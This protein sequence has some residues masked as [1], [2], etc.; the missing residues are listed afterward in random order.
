MSSPGDDFSGRHLPSTLD[1]QN[2][3]AATPTL[4][5]IALFS[6]PPVSPRLLL[7]FFFLPF[8]ELLFGVGHDHAAQTGTR[9]ELVSQQF[10]VLREHLSAFLQ[11]QERKFLR[12]ASTAGATA[13]A[14]AEPQLTSTFSGLAGL[15][16][17][18][19]LIRGLSWYTSARLILPHTAGEH[20]RW[21]HTGWERCFYL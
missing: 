17:S 5:V 21:P 11:A 6:F 8:A 10:D 2:R 14:A 13:G 4:R 20:S 3:K 15:L 7:L 1:G 18:S 19:S 12:H 9:A 16:S